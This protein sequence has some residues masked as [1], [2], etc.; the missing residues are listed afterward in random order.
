MNPKEE[1]ERIVEMFYE[2]QLEI[3]GTGTEIHKKTLKAAINCAILHIKG[4]IDVLIKLRDNASSKFLIKS[5]KDIDYEIIQQQAV[6]E[7][8][9]KM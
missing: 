6:L 7:E 4:I 2:E 1:A 3:S 9:K 5:A 8:L